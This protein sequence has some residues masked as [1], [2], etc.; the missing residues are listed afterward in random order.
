[1]DLVNLQ[2]NESFEIIL[3]GEKVK[4][5]LL[6]SKNNSDEYTFGFDAPKSISIDREEKHKKRG[7]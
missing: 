5:T 4:V 7:S 1:M 3:K 6:K 2:Y